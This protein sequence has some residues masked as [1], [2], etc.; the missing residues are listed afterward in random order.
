MQANASRTESLLPTE[1]SRR[2]R[3]VPNVRGA[4]ASLLGAGVALGLLILPSSASA[5]DEYYGFQNVCGGGCYI[6]SS[7]A[8]TFNR[9]YGFPNGYA[10]SLAC[11]LFNHEGTVNKVGHGTGG[12]AVGWDGGQYVWARV[13]NQNP[14]GFTDYI[15]GWALTP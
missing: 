4:R 10:T 5:Y 12:C 7:G 14:P 13:Y 3:A 1:P 9:N 15:Y 6:E 11:Q 8:H 2:S